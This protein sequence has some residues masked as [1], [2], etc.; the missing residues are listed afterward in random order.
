MNAKDRPCSVTF[1][2]DLLPIFLEKINDLRGSLKCLI[3]S[4]GDACEEEVQPSFPV[5]VFANLLQQP[6]IFSPMGLQIEAEGREAAFA[7]R[8]SCKDTGYKQAADTTITI[9]KRMDCFELHMQQASLY[10]LR[11]Q[12]G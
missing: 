2:R 6:I 9:E 5:S 7:A 11:D 4:V 3:G 8:R 12:I 10:Q 1:H